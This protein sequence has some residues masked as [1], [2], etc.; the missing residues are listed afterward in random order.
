MKGRTLLAPESVCYNF[1]IM[2]QSCS[3]MHDASYPDTVGMKAASLLTK[4]NGCGQ[5]QLHL[6]PGPVVFLDS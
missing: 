4:V 2:A 6:D 1:V 3:C 5:S